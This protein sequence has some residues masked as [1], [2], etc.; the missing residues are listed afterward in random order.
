MTRSGLLKTPIS[1]VWLGLIAATLTSWW[2]GSDHG[3][4]N[5][6]TAG[7]LI[8]LVAFTKVRFVGLFFMELRHAPLP[9]RL[10]FEGWCAV[11]TTTII[12]MFLV[13]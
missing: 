12:V 8:L 5:E 1:L 6:S 7:V 3:V 4:S 13:E 10:I 11:V 2:L 9:L